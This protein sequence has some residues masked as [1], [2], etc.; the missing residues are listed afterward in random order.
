MKNSVLDGIGRKGHCK[1]LFDKSHDDLT[2]QHQ[3][4]RMQRQKIIDGSW[5]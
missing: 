2:G 5:E 1:E 3:Q 4:T